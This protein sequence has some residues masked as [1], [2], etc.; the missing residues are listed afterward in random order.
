MTVHEVPQLIEKEQFLIFLGSTEQSLWVMK[1][2]ET[3]VAAGELADEYEQE[4]RGPRMV[5][6][7]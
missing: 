5:Y 2:R 3:C 6:G 7:E 4:R 1:K